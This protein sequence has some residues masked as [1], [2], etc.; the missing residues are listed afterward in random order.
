MSDSIRDMV[1]EGI[2]SGQLDAAA[3]DRYD[4]AVE[5]TKREIA[6]MMTQPSPLERL[7]ESITGKKPRYEFP[8]RRR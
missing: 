1:L 3:V 4:A 2:A 8:K 6:V 5:R 7:F